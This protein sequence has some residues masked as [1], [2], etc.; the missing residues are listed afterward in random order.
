MGDEGEKGVK[1][2]FFCISPVNML[3]LKVVL[4]LKV[5]VLK[6]VRVVTE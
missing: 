3:V 5:L 2:E 1:G 4:V 6:V